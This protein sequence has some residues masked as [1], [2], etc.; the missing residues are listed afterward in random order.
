MTCV[1]PQRGRSR[2]STLGPPLAWL[3][4]PA[5]RQCGS[6]SR[7]FAVKSHAAAC[8]SGRQSRR[9]LAVHLSCSEPLG[10]SCLW[11]LLFA[12]QK[13][14]FHLCPVV[15]ET[16]AGEAQRQTLCMPD[17]TPA[18]PSSAQPRKHYDAINV[19]CSF[20]RSRPPRL[21][22]SAFLHS[23]EPV[24]DLWKPCMQVPVR[25]CAMR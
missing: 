5:A 1:S 17:P 25:Q 15:P 3:I 10:Y 11:C 2:T 18:K 4:C 23:S 7:L 22:T 16:H 13:G 6:P 14:P 9:R 12:C 21:S 19:L 20:H 8:G 24:S